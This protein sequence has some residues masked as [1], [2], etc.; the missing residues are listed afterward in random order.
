MRLTASG[1]LLMRIFLSPFFSGKKKRDDDD[2]GD[3]IKIYE[4]VSK[5]VRFEFEIILGFRL[6]LNHDVSP[7]AS[8]NIILIR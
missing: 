1:I 8:V 7:T 6:E 3:T 2:K 5:V 4:V